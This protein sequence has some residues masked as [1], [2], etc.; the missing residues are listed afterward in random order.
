[1]T[2]PLERKGLETA[3]LL[4]VVLLQGLSELQA[5]S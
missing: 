2:H 4:T 3:T 5:K 1:M